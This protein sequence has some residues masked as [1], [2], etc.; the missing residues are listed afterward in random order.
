MRQVLNNFQNQS[1]NYIHVIYHSHSIGH[2]HMIGKHISMALH[3]KPLSK[4][5]YGGIK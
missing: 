3:N 4:N 1:Y 5:S 2:K